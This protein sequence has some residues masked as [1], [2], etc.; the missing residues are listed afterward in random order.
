[1]PEFDTSER[2]AILAEFDRLTK[3]GLPRNLTGCGCLLFIGYLRVSQ[4]TEC[5][6]R[7]C[8]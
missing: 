1:M 7:S 8:S 5:D 4:Q 6:L 2:D 3:R